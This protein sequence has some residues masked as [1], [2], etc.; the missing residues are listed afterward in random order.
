[1]RSQTREGGAAAEEGAFLSGEAQRFPSRV[2][3]LEVGKGANP[4]LRLKQEDRGHLFSAWEELRIK[5][6]TGKP[7]RG[8]GS[9]LER[10]SLSPGPAKKDQ[11]E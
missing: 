1:M 2:S 10:M 4:P 3:Y 7:S 8:P 5:E 6:E 11:A 9:W